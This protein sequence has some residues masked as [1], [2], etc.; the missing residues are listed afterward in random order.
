MSVLERLAEHMANGGVGSAPWFDAL[1]AWQR[2]ALWIV[3]MA[4]FLAGVALFV[5]AWLR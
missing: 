4:V 5:S 1:P 2:A 3:C